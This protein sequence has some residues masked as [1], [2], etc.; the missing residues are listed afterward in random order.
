MNQLSCLSWTIDLRDVACHVWDFQLAILQ[1]KQKAGGQILPAPGDTSSPAFLAVSWARNMVISRSFQVFDRFWSGSI[2][3]FPCISLVFNHVLIDFRI[4]CFIQRFIVLSRTRLDSIARWVPRSLAS[5]DR[6]AGAV[7]NRWITMAA[8]R[9]VYALDDLSLVDATGMNHRWYEDDQAIFLEDI[10]FHVPWPQ[11]ALFDLSE[12]S[13][14]FGMSLHEIGLQR[15][16]CPGHSRWMLV[17]VSVPRTPDKWSTMV[18]SGAMSKITIV[19]PCRNKISSITCHGP[20][21][22]RGQASSCLSWSLGK[23]RELFLNKD[24]K[25]V[26]PKTN[27]QFIIFEWEAWPEADRIIDEKT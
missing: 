15:H 12:R 17:R 7:L 5:G 24:P 8:G 9:D 1:A 16:W 4:R 18:I 13:P 23:G 10:S 11:M 22:S 19:L 20:W 2:L 21:A 6:K 14:C 27:T 26:K 3:V 25:S